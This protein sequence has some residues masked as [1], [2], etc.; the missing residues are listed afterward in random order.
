MYVP[1]PFIRSPYAAH[2]EFSLRLIN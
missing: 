2:F 1:L